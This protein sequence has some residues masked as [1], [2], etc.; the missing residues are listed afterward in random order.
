MHLFFEQDSKTS[1]NQNNAY[2]MYMAKHMASL[3]GHNLL[4]NF[5]PF[6]S[7]MRP[8]NLAFNESIAAGFYSS[9]CIFSLTE[10]TWTIL[11]QMYN[12]RNKSQDCLQR[13]RVAFNFG[14]GSAMCK[15]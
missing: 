1:V 2:F 7:R 9:F 3:E 11:I 6:L 4:K 15:R 14:N 8:I 12:V 13:K 10:W 5:S